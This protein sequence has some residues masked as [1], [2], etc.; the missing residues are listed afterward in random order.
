MGQK[1]FVIILMLIGTALYAQSDDLTGF[2]PELIDTTIKP[3]DDFYTYASGLWLKNATLPEGY[4]RFGY[5]N[6]A[7]KI[8]EEKIIDLMNGSALLDPDNHLANLVTNLYL[9]GMD[10]VRINN[11][12]IGAIT[13]ELDLI[14]AIKTPDDLQKVIT[15]FILIGIDP[16][17]EIYRPQPWQILDTNYLCFIQT[18]LGLPNSADYLTETDDPNSKRNQ[19]KS[20]IVDLLSLVTNDNN[21]LNSDAEDVLSIETELASKMMDP[22]ELRNFDKTYNLYKINKLKSL[23][24]Q[25]DW[26][27]F[28]NDL[29]KTGTNKV[30]IGQPKYFKEI[31]KILKTYDIESLKTYL[32]FILIYRTS[33]YLYSKAADLFWKFKIDICGWQE[34]PRSVFI[35]DIVTREMPDAI[36]ALF[37][38]TYFPPAKKD[39]IAIMITNLKEAFRNRIQNNE[40]ISESSKNNILIKLNNMKFMVGGPEKYVDYDK[41]V[42]TKSNFIQNLFHVREFSNR[43]HTARMGTAKDFQAWSVYPH[44]TN[45]WYS[46]GKNAITLPAGNINEF[47]TDDDNAWNYG[48]LGATIAHEMTHGFDADGR[49]YDENGKTFGF[50]DKMKGWWDDSDN[51]FQNCADRMEKKYDKFVVLDSFYVNGENTLNENLADLGGLNIAYDAYILSL[52]R[53][54]PDTIAGFSGPQR[55]FL[56]YAQKWRELFEEETLIESLR[57]YHAPP[58]YRTNGI[59]YNVTG[60][61]D[62]FNIDESD[63]MYLHP[64]DRIVIW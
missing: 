64:K 3:G 45:A 15:K 62:A 53:P 5:Y 51:H 13:S 40:W 29:G 35:Y 27:V 39:K 50:W 59:V 43:R 14:D 34:I 28:L 47:W 19:Y 63:K 20:F 10:S 2:K 60:F 41:L 17:F 56:S 11:I 18:R 12:G 38:K 46:A 9:S 21:N 26:E 48:T 37:I 36:G 24:Q 22:K 30:V 49:K 52:N 31:G 4:G 7:D 58:Q 1:L 8:I 32:K 23:I 33:P 61:Y 54:E 6:L 25:F 55:F 44:S 42:F 57:G 16:F